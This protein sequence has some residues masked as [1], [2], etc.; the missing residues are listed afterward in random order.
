[1]LVEVVGG[2]EENQTD[3]SPSPAPEDPKNLCIPRTQ[4]SLL[5]S[6]AWVSISWLGRWG[7]KVGEENSGWEKR[8]L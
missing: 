6:S 2:G 5:M 7:L 3:T 8:K 4:I 1:V